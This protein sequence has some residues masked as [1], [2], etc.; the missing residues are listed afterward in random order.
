M[1]NVTA[2]IMIEICS[3]LAFGKTNLQINVL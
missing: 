1:V 3:D 2:Y